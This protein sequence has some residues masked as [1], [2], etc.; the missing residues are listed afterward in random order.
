M[1]TKRTELPL[2]YTRNLTTTARIAAQLSYIVNEV[3]QDMQYFH[4][5]NL[6]KNWQITLVKK[7]PKNWCKLAKNICFL[8]KATNELKLELNELPSQYSISTYP[9][10][11]KD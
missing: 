9:S 6:S 1:S 8:D 5:R 3:N 10:S 2:V 4:E 7:N 11:S